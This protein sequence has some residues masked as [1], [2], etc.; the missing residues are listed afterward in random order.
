[1]FQ[2]RDFYAIIAEILAY[3][4]NIAYLCALKCI[5]SIYVKNEIVLY[6][7][8]NTIQLEVRLLDETVWLSQQQMV[9]LFESTK[10]NVVALKMIE[11]PYWHHKESHKC[12]KINELYF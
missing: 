3:L 8:D 10:Q 5:L 4:K 2:N 7:P 9:A 12:H 6:Q 11:V 1:M